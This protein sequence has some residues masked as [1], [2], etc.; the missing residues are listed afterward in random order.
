M[1]QDKADFLDRFHVSRETSERLETY[2]ALLERWTKR[3]N[4]IS[5]R[6]LPDLWTRHFLD[7]AQLL[8]V[9]P[10]GAQSWADLGSGAGFPGAVVAILTRGAPGPKVTLVESDQRKAA[11]LRSV[12][13]ETGVGFDIIS[14]RIEDID[15]LRADIVS[16]RALAP[17]DTLLGYA[18]RHL[19]PGGRALFPKGQK[20]G[21][22]VAEA[23][24]HWRIDCES[25][26]S[27]TDP[28]AVIL[29]IGDIKRV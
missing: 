7:S 15:P 9:A 22:E 4:L 6:T 23:L 20:A 10:K 8:S 18:E 26:P 25:H 2:A 29:S 21:H 24:E 14:K 13:R 16:A 12:A 1:N 27:E 17:L 5:P 19:A 3:I 11:F 28:E